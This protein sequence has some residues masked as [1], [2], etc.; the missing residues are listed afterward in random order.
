MSSDRII[1]IG[2]FGEGRVGKT[3]LLRRYLDKDF[4]PREPSTIVPSMKPIYFKRE[5]KV[6]EIQL[7]DTAGQ[8]TYRELTKQYITGLNGIILVFDLTGME[9]FGKVKDWFDSIKENTDVEKT[10]ICLVGNKLDLKEKK[11]VNSEEAKKIGES[12]GMTYMETSAFTGEKVDE[13]YNFVI[14][15][16]IKNGFYI[17]T[18][19]RVELDKP[20][21]KSKRCC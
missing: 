6:Y 21:N 16:C 14:D 11:V 12:F 4:K 15:N 17:E 1:K 19:D 7:Y 5:Q 20:K 13:L 10:V 18:E 2:M 8:E 9:T 3:S